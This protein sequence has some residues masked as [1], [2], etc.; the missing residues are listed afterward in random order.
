M[1]K[2]YNEN[3]NA[4]EK[5][6]HA[7]HRKIAIWNLSGEQKAELAKQVITDAQTELEYRSQM[8]LS[9]VIATL[10]LL[11]NATPVVIG[12]MIIAPILR[13]IQGVAFATTTG[14]KRLFVK[15]L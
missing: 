8:F 2:E 9:I 1:S 5:L 13:P 14:N 3:M 12:A 10:G 11:I 7:I 15:S 4:S 6:P